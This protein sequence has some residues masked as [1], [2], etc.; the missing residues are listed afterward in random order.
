MA[1][2]TATTSDITANQVK[3]CILNNALV[4][5][6]PGAD[7]LSMLHPSDYSAIRFSCPQARC[8]AGQ[9]AM[10]LYSS[11]DEVVGVS[12]I[13]IVTD[14]D[15]CPAVAHVQVQDPTFAAR[16]KG[17]FDRYLTWVPQTKMTIVQVPV[18]IGY[19]SSSGD[20]PNIPGL[21]LQLLRDRHAMIRARD[22]PA[23]PECAVCLTEAEESILTPCRHRY[24]RA[25]FI[26]QC[27]SITD[28]EQGEIPLRC[29]G[30]SGTCS[31]IFLLPE[32]DQLLDPPI[33]DHLLSQSLT[34][35]LKTLTTIIPCPTPDCNHQYRSR[36]DG[37]VLTCPKCSNPICTTCQTPSHAGM[38]CRI[39]Q[40]T[41]KKIGYERWWL[42][43]KED[44]RKCPR[45]RNLVEKVAGG[46]RRMTCGCCRAGFCWSCM[47]VWDEGGRCR[48]TR[49]KDG[50]VKERM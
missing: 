47:E 30:D 26:A 41:G 10:Y 3:T 5:F 38:T 24:C 37:L 48:C 20:Q 36:T 2:T 11:F 16:I 15:E 19:E 9:M 45:C 46:C 42:E 8:T 34:L 40:K 21:Q 49:G 33:F 13:H 22:R 6:G 25:C 18:E 4:T 29:L 14:P 17:R 12:R 27:S 39:Y 23:A 31:R 28:N 50:K 35:H 44:I 32:L 43:N 1:T 7:V